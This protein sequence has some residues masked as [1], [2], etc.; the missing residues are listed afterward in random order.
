[1]TAVEQRPS[2]PRNPR[3]AGWLDGPTYDLSLVVLPAVI[4][5]ASVAAVL[6]QPNLFF[7]ILFAD[8]WLLGYHHVIS[9]FT[10]FDTKEAR[11]QWKSLITWVP[12]AVLAG[13][14]VLGYVIGFWAIASLYLV[15]QAAH[16][17][18]QQWGIHRVYQR[19][20]GVGLQDNLRT[21]AGFYAVAVWGIVNR[22]AQNPDEFLGLEI[23]TV[24]VPSP[25]LWAVGVICAGLMAT[26]LFDVGRAWF[27][28]QVSNIHA[29]HLVINQ[30]I[31]FVAYIGVSNIDYGW[32]G[33]NIYHNMQYVLFVWF[34]NHQ[35]YT[36]NGE[37]NGVVARL[38]RRRNPFAYLT[39][40]FLISTVLYLSLLST[41][42]AVTSSLVIFMSLNFAHY[43]QDSF[44][45]KVR[46]KPM[47]ET[48][49]LS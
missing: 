46:Q 1:M 35:R 3:P 47:Q 2:S 12:V 23:R 7:P 20:S 49:G 8:L 11:Q 26:H 30:V 42:A 32:L 10:R 43:V 31:F 18:R 37:H 38:S 5:L 34:F 41:V 15:W 25:V 33:I 17:S 40:C 29:S 19:K 27:N 6:A 22:S 24:P 4:G 45:W 9:T 28:G 16:Y 14:A 39:I 13:T 48:L 44:I 36:K 21:K